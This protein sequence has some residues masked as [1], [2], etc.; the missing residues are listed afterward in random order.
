MLKRNSRADKPNTIW[1]TDFTYIH[2]T[3]GTMRYNCAIIDLY[4]RAVVATITGKEI[5]SELALQTLKSA[6]RFRIQNNL[7]LH[8]DQ[9]SQFTSKEFT[10]FCKKMNITQN[11][12]KAGCP[13]DNA[14]MERYF[15]TLKSELINQHYFNNDAELERK[16]QKFAFWWYNRRRPHSYK[17]GI[18]P[19]KVKK[20]V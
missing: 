9:G 4:N 11:M 7:I 17:G 15:N 2:K 3:D 16:I 5:T 14:V 13:Y 6:L 1:R 19:M 20:S 10:D 12:S 8:S 18:P